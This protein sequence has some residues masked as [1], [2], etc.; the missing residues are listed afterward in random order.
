MEPSLQEVRQ[1]LDHYRDAVVAS[2]RADHIAER[3]DALAA[4]TAQPAYAEGATLAHRRAAR[5]RQRLRAAEAAL[6]HGAPP[7]ER[8]WLTPDDPD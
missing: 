1:V 4:A 8:P 2:R 6:T 5:E 3:L 7:L